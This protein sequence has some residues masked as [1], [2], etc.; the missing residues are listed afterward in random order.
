[1]KLDCEGAEYDIATTDLKSVAQI[2]GEYHVMDNKNP[3]ELQTRL[4][5]QNFYI[6]EWR[7]FEER[8]NGD[9]YNSGIFWAIRK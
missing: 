1:M 3:I 6:K 8:K 9:D 7:E 4:L 2:V 5:D